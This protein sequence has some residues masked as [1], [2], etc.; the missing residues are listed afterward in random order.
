MAGLSYISELQSTG[1][2]RDLVKNVKLFSIAILRITLFGGPTGYHKVPFCAA[3]QLS[4]DQPL[5]L[6]LGEGGLEV[7]VEAILDEFFR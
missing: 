4:V 3:E 7:R 2:A 1:K 5:D 6:C